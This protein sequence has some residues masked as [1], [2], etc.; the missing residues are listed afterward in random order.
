MF[1]Y[2]FH[3]ADSIHIGICLLNFDLDNINLAGNF[4]FC[5]AKI[6]QFSSQHLVEASLFAEG[7]KVVQFKPFEGIVT[8]GKLVIEYQ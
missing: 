8:P 4:A 5:S 3:A 1:S 7:G 6:S 2:F